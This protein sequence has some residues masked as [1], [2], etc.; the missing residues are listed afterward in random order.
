M[1]VSEREREKKSIP[2]T[3]EETIHIFIRKFFFA[4]VKLLLNF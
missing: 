3:K 2:K 1:L 4:N